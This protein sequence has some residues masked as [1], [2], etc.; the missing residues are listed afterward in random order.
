MDS[1]VT[2]GID[3]MS[4]CLTTNHLAAFRDGILSP[5][6]QTRLADHLRICSSCRQKFR[7]LNAGDQGLADTLTACDTENVGH[8][9]HA[10]NDAQTH[11]PGYRILSR[12]GRGGQGDVY[13]A[14]QTSTKRKVAL[15]VFSSRSHFG[16]DRFQRETQI[17]ARLKNPRI[18]TIYESGQTSLGQSYFAMEYISGLTLD[19]YVAAKR[20][21]RRRTLELFVKICSAVDAAHQNTVIHR[22]LK[23]ENL[24]I[25]SRGEPHV[26]DFGL[27]KIA[28]PILTST[29]VPA[30]ATGFMGSLEY[31]SPEQAEGDNSLV[32][33]R[34]DVYSLGVI[35]YRLVTDRFPYPVDGK[36]AEVLKNITEME[37][38]PLPHWAPRVATTKNGRTPPPR[39]EH[40]LKT[41]I[42]RALSKQ[43]ARRYQSAGNLERDVQRY[44]DGE[45]IEAKLDSP[46]YVL[47]KLATRYRYA[48]GVMGTVLLILISSG[49][50]TFDQFRQA[51][52]AVNERL[53]LAEETKRKATTIASLSEPLPDVVR[54]LTL[55]WFLLEWHAE[56]DVSAYEIY[57]KTKRPTPESAVMEFL[58]SGT[59]NCEAII[60]QPGVSES[61]AY[62]ACAERLSKNRRLLEAG[63]MYEQALK[64]SPGEWLKSRI[65]ARLKKLQSRVSHAFESKKSE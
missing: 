26:L 30:S 55:G 65:Q 52:R 7:K 61:L 37:P 41:I 24:L 36:L 13:K 6:E 8:V 4:R 5:H 29:G 45:A 46:L 20:P 3:G 63:E 11:V 35:L 62:F 19:K 32:D 53:E 47:R 21:D 58:L 31:T 64:W 51:Q 25:D 22:D 49:Y 27:A 14:I 1:S 54:R 2:D 44:L 40:D 9:S 10:S 42:L 12:I 43:P 57:T 50:L 16:S 18:V 17:L 33:I 39:V 48:T 34:A 28:E 23:P 38:Q 56:L 60:G 59:E 15:K